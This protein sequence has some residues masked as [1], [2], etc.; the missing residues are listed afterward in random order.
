MIRDETAVNHLKK[1][2]VISSSSGAIQVL[3]NTFLLA[4]RVDFD[5]PAGCSGLIALSVYTILFFTLD[6]GIVI[7]LVK[8]PWVHGLNKS[9]VPSHNGGTIY[10][11]TI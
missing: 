5:R 8:N 1:I 2:T 3:H 4:L 11:V 6:G 7:A 10:R 9:R